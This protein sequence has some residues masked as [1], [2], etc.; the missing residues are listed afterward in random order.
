LKKFLKTARNHHIPMEWMN[1]GWIYC[2]D[3]EVNGIL[4]YFHTCTTEFQFVLWIAQWINCK[5]VDS[6]YITWKDRVWH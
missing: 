5:R 1:T 2:L 6:V 3:P 4:S